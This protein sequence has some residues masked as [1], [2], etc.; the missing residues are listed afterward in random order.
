ME[1]SDN[2]VCLIVSCNELASERV[3]IGSTDVLVCPAHAKEIE[4]EKKR[5]D[6]IIHVRKGT[7]KKL[8]MASSR[9]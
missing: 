2:Y 7:I 6:G 5:P 9:G 8:A 4:E 1:P 3:D